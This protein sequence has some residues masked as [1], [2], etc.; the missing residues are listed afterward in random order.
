M[1]VNSAHA[2]KGIALANRKKRA[3]RGPRKITL[4]SGE[5]AQVFLGDARDLSSQLIPDS[6]DVTITSP[7]YFDIKDYGAKGQIGFGQSYKAYLDDLVAIFEKVAIATKKHGSL[8]IVIDTF[9]RNNVVQPLPFDLAAS[10]DA[11]G[12]TLRDVVIW[13]KDRTL[14]WLQPGMTRRIFEYI[15]V[16]AK[17][18]E[19]FRY[20]PDRERDFVD[21]KRWWIRYPERY[22]PK[23]KSLEEVWTFDIPIQGSWS[24]QDLRHFCPMPTDLVKRVINLTTDPGDTVLD[25]FAGSGTVPFQAKVMD[26]KGIGF[27]IN[28]RYAKAIQSRLSQEVDAG[29]AP[30][31]TRLTAAEFERRIIDLRLLKFGRL[32]FRL[33]NR[34]SPEALV[35]HV[36]VCRQRRRPKG[37][38]HLVAAEFTLVGSQE[39]EFSRLKEVISKRLNEPPL[40]KFGIEAS[41]LLRGKSEVLKGVRRG[42]LYAYSSTNTHKFGASGSLGL[43]LSGRHPVISAIRVS[44]EEP[45]G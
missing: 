16:L 30:N 32:L 40:S 8:W 3:L 20:Y 25:P 18:G 43:L 35:T 37:R 45:D 9:R 22:S 24:R 12:W 17:K 28:R 23:G 39:S 42:R 10:L 27:E 33:V 41:V 44:M 5:K 31:A 26:R 14:P 15:L 21:L 38:Y 1:G 6:V 29:A 11:A 36:L 2:G 19:S 13:K 34:V 4:K 7:P